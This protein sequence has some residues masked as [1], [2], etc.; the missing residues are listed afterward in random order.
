MQHQHLLKGTLMRTSS[1]NN[2][3]HSPGITA[4]HTSAST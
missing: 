3:I 1:G 4:Q 2:D